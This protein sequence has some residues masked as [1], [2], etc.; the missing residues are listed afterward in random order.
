MRWGLVPFWILL[1]K[2]GGAT[3]V[4]EKRTFQKVW[5]ITSGLSVIRSQPGNLESFTSLNESL[6]DSSTTNVRTRRKSDACYVQKGPRSPGPL[7]EQ[8][9]LLATGS[10]S[11]AGGSPERVEVTHEGVAPDIRRGALRRL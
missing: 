11:P 6:G 2:S 5:R 3:E 4:S 8:V 7:Y 1:A 10:L 9:Q